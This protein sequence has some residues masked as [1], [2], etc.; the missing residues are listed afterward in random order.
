M[1]SGVERKRFLQLVRKTKW[2]STCAVEAGGSQPLTAV[3]LLR[4]RG[5]AFGL[6]EPS[7]ARRGPHDDGLRS[8]SAAVR[9]HSNKRCPWVGPGALRKPVPGA[10]STRHRRVP[11][12][13]DRSCESPAPC[14]R[15]TIG[16]NGVCRGSSCT[17]TAISR[18]DSTGGWAT[19][20]P[21]RSS[22]LSSRSWASPDPAIKGP[23]CDRTRPTSARTPS[24]SPMA[25]SCASSR[26]SCRR[27]RPPLTKREIV[28]CRSWSVVMIPPFPSLAGMSGSEQANPFQA[29]R[30]GCRLP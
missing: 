5:P 11:R 9:R 2:F 1:R 19:S 26:F 21:S 22:I 13:S 28:C 15:I 17:S 23:T 30:G 14:C 4:L 3:P 29:D 24:S 25:A 10:A 18:R 12:H 16:G 7:R 20:M 27:L 8:A 6:T